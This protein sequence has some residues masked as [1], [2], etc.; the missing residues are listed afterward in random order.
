MELWREEG[1]NLTTF[2]SLLFLWSSLS[3]GWFLSNLSL[4]RSFFSWLFRFLFYWHGVVVN[5]VKKVLQKL[6]SF[7]QNS[8]RTLI[9]NPSR[10]W[11]NIL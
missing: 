1:L 3:L 8:T 7:L 9:Q 10:K 6:S 11:K 5:G 2:S 4:R